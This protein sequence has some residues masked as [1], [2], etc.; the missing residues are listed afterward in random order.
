MP[1]SFM[2]DAVTVIRAPLIRKN[3]AQ[4]RDWDNA[5][6]HIVE[7]VQV[8]AQ[9][10]SREFDS[11]TTQN[12]DRRTLRTAYEADIKTGDHIEWNGNLYEID[13]EVFHTKSPTGRASSTR[14]SLA[15]WE[16]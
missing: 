2:N 9:A 6:R 14:C 10:T 13:G 1:L 15:R 12:T 8:T 4:I 11:R 5:E 16:G 7:H 3:G